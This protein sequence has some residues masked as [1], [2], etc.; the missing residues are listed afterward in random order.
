LDGR[1]GDYLLDGAAAI[2]ALFDVGIGK[3][4]NSLKTVTA[5]LALI[6]VKW[7]WTPELGGCDFDSRFSRD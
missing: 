3:L 1:S 5:L 7:H 2:R 4:L 6:F